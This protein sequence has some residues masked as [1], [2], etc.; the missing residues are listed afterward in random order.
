MARCRDEGVLFTCTPVSTGW[1]YFDDDFDHHPIG[2]MREFGLKISLDCDDVFEVGEEIVVNGMCSEVGSDLE[3]TVHDT[4]TGEAVRNDFLEPDGDGWE[5]AGLRPLPEG[6][7]RITLSASGVN[8][9]C[10]TDMFV[11]FAPDR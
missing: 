3:V 11:V 5:P 2:R 9:Q 4:E 10:V 1:V 8:A 6:S 7:Y